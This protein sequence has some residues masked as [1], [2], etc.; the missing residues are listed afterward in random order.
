MSD[1]RGRAR[2]GEIKR[3]TGGWAIRY[4]TAAACGG[5]AAGSGRRREAKL[6][7]DDELR[8]AQ[9]GPLYRPETTLQQLVDAFLEQ[10]QGA[11]ASKTGCATT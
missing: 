11:P 7:L 10:Y 2:T 5:S 6:A 1:G 3:T 9:L 4:R 8:K